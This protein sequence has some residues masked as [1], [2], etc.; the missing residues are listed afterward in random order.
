MSLVLSFLVFLLVFIGIQSFPSINT[1]T[2]ALTLKALLDYEATTHYL[3]YLRI[4][5]STKALTGNITVK[6]KYGLTG[7][8]VSLQDA[9][10]RPRSSP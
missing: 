6:V 5:D 10:N 1:S 2:A 8:I 9:G 3:L 4:T 7:S